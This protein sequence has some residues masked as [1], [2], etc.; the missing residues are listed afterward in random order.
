LT[1]LLGHQEEHQACKKFSDEVLAWLS[2]WSEVRTACIV[3]PVL[4]PLQNVIITCLIRTWNGFAFLV[5]A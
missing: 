1:P 2:V 5:P 4:L 3:Q